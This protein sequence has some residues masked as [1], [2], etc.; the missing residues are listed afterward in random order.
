MRRR[1]LCASIIVADRLSC[2]LTPVGEFYFLNWETFASV[3]DHK[4]DEHFQLGR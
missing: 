4:L 2:Q 3:V 1:H